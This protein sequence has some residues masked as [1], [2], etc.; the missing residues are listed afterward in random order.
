MKLAYQSQQMSTAL[1]FFFLNELH[2]IFLKQ[3]NN[4]K[5]QHLVFF[6]RK[7]ESSL[8]LKVV[9]KDFILIKWYSCVLQR[10]ITENGE[11]VMKTFTVCS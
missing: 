3:I 10:E 5:L 11:N 4:N 9:L 1:P 7:C 8:H 6:F 2:L